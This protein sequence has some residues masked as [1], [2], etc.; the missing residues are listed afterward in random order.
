MQTSDSFIVLGSEEVKAACLRIIS[1][2]KA[3][4]DK[5]RTQFIQE[6]TEAINLARAR[7]RYIGIRLKPRT[8]EQ[9]EAEIEGGKACW[10]DLFEYRTAS[11]WLHEQQ[12]DAA[13]YLLSMSQKSDVVWLSRSD[14][15]HIF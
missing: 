9:V 11:D 12:Y 14:Y 13:K 8:C 6:R 10:M 15:S 3:A 4:R 2:I 5:A 7:W 1:S